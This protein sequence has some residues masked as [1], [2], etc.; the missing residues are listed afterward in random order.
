MDLTCSTS[1][2][3]GAYNEFRWQRDSEGWSDPTDQTTDLDNLHVA[4]INTSLAPA[5]GDTFKSQVRLEDVYENNS[6]WLDMPTLVLDISDDTAPTV[7]PIAMEVY[8]DGATV[9][10]YYSLEIEGEPNGAEVEWAW[11][12]NGGAWYEQGSYD[13]QFT[14]PIHSGTISTGREI[15]DG[16]TYQVQAR[17]KDRSGNISDWTDIGTDVVDVSPSGSPAISD[18]LSGS[19]AY[20]HG[21]S[22]TITGQNFGGT[23]GPPVV[24]DDVEGGA[25]DDRWQAAYPDV[26]RFSRHPNSGHSGTHDFGSD[27]ARG[28]FTSPNATLSDKWY[29]LTITVLR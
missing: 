1:E 28:Y 25:F 18:V 10:L 12:V 23:G 26:S 24:W 7:T 5:D 29:V 27:G 9:E 2:D 19:G 8:D 4:N 6:G 21:V 3:N 16:D 14:A 13:G 17:A 20:N 15:I 22:L 11:R